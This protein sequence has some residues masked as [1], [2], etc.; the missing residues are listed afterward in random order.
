MRQRGSFFVLAVAVILSAATAQAFD[1]SKYPN[2]RGQRVGLDVD[3]SSPWDPSGQKALL[4]AEYQA[5]FEASPTPMGACSRAL[6]SQPSPGYSIGE[7]Q[8]SNKGGGFDTLL[9]E[10]RAIK[11][12][13]AVIG[14]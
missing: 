2:W 5:I 4:T 8:G 7:W 14:E 12:P 9:I 1:E 3:P 11:G 13:P 10:T 6:S